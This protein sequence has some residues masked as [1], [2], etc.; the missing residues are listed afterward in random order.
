MLHLQLKQTLNNEKDKNKLLNLQTY[1]MLFH[2]IQKFSNLPNSHLV[3]K[4]LIG[5][6]ILQGYNP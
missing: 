1:K 2:S 4:T 5:E 3:S 6:N